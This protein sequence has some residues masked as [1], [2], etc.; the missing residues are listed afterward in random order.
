EQ[1]VAAHKRQ[2]EMLSKEEEFIARFAAR[3]SHAAQVQSRVKKL[4]KIER[5]EM[6]AEEKVM[7]FEFPN[8]PRSGNEAVKIQNLGKKWHLDDGSFK[9][10]FSG[11][12][13]VIKRLDK[14]AIVGVNGA[15]KS[16]LLKIM[17]GQTEPTNGALVIGAAV[18][19]GY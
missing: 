5:I 11:A 15:G 2:Q 13:G 8:P 12:N 16:T 7:R 19:V 1:L 4:E 17:A 9:P 18:K 14:V 3:A 6:P 10:V